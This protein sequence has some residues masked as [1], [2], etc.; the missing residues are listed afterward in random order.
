MIV[1]HIGMRKCGSASLQTFLSENAEG[2]RELSLDYPELGRGKTQQHHNFA[3]E[4]Q[5]LNRFRPDDGTLSQCT[6]Y[7][8]KSEHRVM[9]LSSE[10]FE[11]AKDHEVLALRDKLLKTNRRGGFRIYLVVR[12]LVDLMPSSYAQKVKYGRNTHDFDTF[13]A[14]RMQEERVHFFQI[15]KRWAKPFGWK[16]LHVRVLDPAHLFNRD[17]IDDFLAVCGVTEEKDRL[18]LKRTGVRN[19]SPGWRVLEATR[20]LCNGSHGLQPYHPLT[21]ISTNMSEGL[22]KIVGL[23]AIEIGDKRGWNSERGSYLTCEQA[24]RCY[25]TYRN[26]VLRLNEKLVQKLP[27]PADLDTRGFSEREFMPEASRI[28]RRKLKAFYDELWDLL[29]KKPAIEQR[30][31]EA[32]AAP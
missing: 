3:R 14:E 6:K 12:D 2:L 1:L 18:K 29:R 16:N 26:N 13:F 30:L 11:E 10:L 28:P 27:E 24:Q 17:L 9:I 7:W 4:L 21:A 31:T 22:G 8:K 15:A 19:E 5:G 32:R 23:A 20:A 25:E